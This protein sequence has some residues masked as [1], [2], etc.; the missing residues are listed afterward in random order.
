MY[1]IVLLGVVAE[2]TFAE[3]LLNFGRHLI[4]ETKKGHREIFLQGVLE[5][6]GH[7]PNSSMLELA[8]LF[9]ET[10]NSIKFRALVEDWDA[11][12]IQWAVL[13]PDSSR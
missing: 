3:G 4:E 5:A 6:S 7:L 10:S 12:T 11:M 8:E 13:F 1:E 2:I 9:A